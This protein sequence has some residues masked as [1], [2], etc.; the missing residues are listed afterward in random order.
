MKYFL[1]FFAAPVLVTNI[2]LDTL[3][4]LFSSFDKENIKNIMNEKL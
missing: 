4:V 2:F 3:R 1:G